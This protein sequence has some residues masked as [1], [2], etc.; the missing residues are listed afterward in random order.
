LALGQNNFKTASNDIFIIN[1]KINNVMH[2]EKMNYKK[3]EMRL[4]KASRAKNAFGQ[5][6]GC[7]F[8]L[9]QRRLEVFMKLLHSFSCSVGAFFSTNYG[10]IAAFGKHALNVY[11][12]LMTWI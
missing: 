11:S 7:L 4:E 12:D 2:F 9:W 5:C 1:S 10:N 3:T 8:K 6:V